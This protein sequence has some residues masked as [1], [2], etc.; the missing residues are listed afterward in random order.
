M[1]KYVY[2]A[3]PCEQMMHP[4]IKIGHTHC[5]P[6]KLLADYNRCSRMEWGGVFWQ[7]AKGSAY[8]W[9]QRVLAL[10]SPYRI[11]RHFGM[12]EVIEMECGGT[13]FDDIYQSLR[14]DFDASL[15]CSATQT[16]A[17]LEKRWAVSVAWL[18]SIEEHLQY[19]D[20]YCGYTPSPSPKLRH[21]LVDRLQKELRGR[22]LVKLPLAAL[23]TFFRAVPEIRFYGSPLEVAT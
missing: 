14:D 1:S 8:E 21:A 6:E 9:E 23:T 10:F 19:L 13:M 22:V 7:I 5:E 16:F 18:N 20:I 15:S 3:A 11:G 17:E 2:V 12:S 4:I